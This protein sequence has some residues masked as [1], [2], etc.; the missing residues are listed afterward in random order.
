MMRGDGSRLTRNQQRSSSLGRGAITESAWGGRDR[1]RFGRFN[2]FPRSAWEC[3]L[4]R[5]ASAIGADRRRAAERP[6]RHSHA[7]RGNE[8]KITIIAMAPPPLQRGDTGG[9]N[10]PTSRPVSRICPPCPGGVAA[11]GHG[12][13]RISSQTTSC[14]FATPVA[15]NRGYPWSHQNKGVNHFKHIRAWECRL[16]RSAS[17]MDIDRRRAAESSSG[18]GIPHPTKVSIVPTSVGWGHGRVPW[19]ALR[20]VPGYSTL[21]PATQKDLPESRATPDEPGVSIP[22]HC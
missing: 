21:I 15:S 17:A 6:G 4:R 7:E 18:G 20:T 8:W 1:S 10:P 5:S 12:D 2:S 11:R 13:V 14:R 16:R 22:C 3:R 9:S 19:K